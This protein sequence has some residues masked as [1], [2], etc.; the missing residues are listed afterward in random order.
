[1]YSWVFGGHTAVPRPA[2]C[3]IG[4]RRLRIAPTSS[5]E[6][7][8]HGKRR[9][10]VISSRDERADGDLP[11]LDGHAVVLDSVLLI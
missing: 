5:V 7:D 2:V 8:Q 4:T 11:A 10:L 1:M 6:P 9:G 3:E